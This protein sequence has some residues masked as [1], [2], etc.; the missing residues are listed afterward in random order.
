MDPETLTSLA[1]ALERLLV[2][3]A[4]TLTV[5]C[6]YRLF[7]LFPPAY[8]N[9]SGRLELPGVKVVFARVG[10]GLLFAA[11]GIAILAVNLK[12]PVSITDSRGTRISS[13][14]GPVTSSPTLFAELSELNCMKEIIPNPRT[15]Y[16]GNVDTARGAL[17][18]A[19]EALLLANWKKEWGDPATFRSWVKDPATG[20]VNPF[21]EK[22][23]NATP[24]AACTEPR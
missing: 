4:G 11:L 16:P 22:L 6:G 3:V 10:P 12:S 14:V 18:S 23:F 13:S 17:T 5:Y 8:A 24:A 20:T 19:R 1:R 7:S 15:K 2:V 21:V 9:S